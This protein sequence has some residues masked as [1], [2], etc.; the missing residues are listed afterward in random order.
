[1]F[2]VCNK[3]AFFTVHNKPIGNGRSAF[4]AR[5]EMPDSAF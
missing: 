3:D 5:A 1:M 2:F 4:P